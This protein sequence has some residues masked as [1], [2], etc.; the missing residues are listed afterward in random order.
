MLPGDQVNDNNLTFSF[1]VGGDAANRY[2]DDLNGTL[3]MVDPL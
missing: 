2:T 1:E 3:R